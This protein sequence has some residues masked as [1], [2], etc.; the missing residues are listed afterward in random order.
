MGGFKKRLAPS[1]LQRAS[2]F[3]GRDIFVPGF[4]R[5]EGPTN[6]R[7]K[8]FDDCTFYGP[9]VIAIADS[10]LSDN[11]WM[12]NLDHILWEVPD[13]AQRVGVFGFIDCTFR[14]CTFHE[15]GLSG[16]AAEVAY[17]RSTF[18]VRP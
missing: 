7:E 6:I 11:V 9:A 16:T 12:N 2:Y 14:R 17:W 10:K 4:G 8:T 5:G 1:A 3:R 13:N 18:T 15:I